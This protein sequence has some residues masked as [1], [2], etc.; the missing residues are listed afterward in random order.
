[1]FS[2]GMDLVLEYRAVLE[3][4]NNSLSKRAM[5]VVDVEFPVIFGSAKWA[6]MFKL[7]YI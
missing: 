5:S 4:I 1:M 6:M 7:Q 2:R 3:I